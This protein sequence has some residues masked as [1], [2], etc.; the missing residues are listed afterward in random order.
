MK[1][2][3]V[4]GGI[5]N[6][7][8]QYAFFYSLKSNS[9]CIVKLDILGFNNYSLHNG[10]EL[11]RVFNLGEK[12][13]TEEEKLNFTSHQFPLI[14]KIKRKLLLKKTLSIVETVEDEYCFN[15]TF[16]STEL[17]KGYYKGYWQS[18]RYFQDNRNALLRQLKFPNFN[19]N[20]QNK[21]LENKIKNMEAISIHVRRGDYVNH[22]LFG[23]LCDLDYYKQ[24]IEHIASKVNNPL[25]IIFSNDIN[26][27]KANLNIPG[28]VVF[29][30]WNKAE[31][32]YRDMQLMSL[33]KHNIIANS[34]FSWWGA[35]L[36]ISDEKIVIAPKK[37]TNLDK[38]NFEICPEEWVLI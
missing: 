30:D 8:F 38:D 35:W 19:E 6:Q 36:N 33:C 18:Y 13:V 27:T 17:T 29:V 24:A 15:P 32:S 10:Y 3:N 22:S 1:I 31:N 34:S 28:Q 26:W 16:L 11:E 37:W 21:L 12:Y 23:G 14:K 25:F 7:L 2:V 9:N 4:I 5:G 20:S